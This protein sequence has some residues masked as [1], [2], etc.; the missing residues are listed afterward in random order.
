ML[1][2]SPL[3]RW[4]SAYL[5][6]AP[7]WLITILSLAQAGRHMST[8]LCSAGGKP[9]MMFATACNELAGGCHRLQSIAQEA[10]I[11]FLAMSLWEVNCTVSCM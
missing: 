8:W 6:A 3:R 7:T 2:Q 1:H 4:T 5:G 10:F 9:T 11:A